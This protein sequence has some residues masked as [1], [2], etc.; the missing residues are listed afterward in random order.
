MSSGESEPD[1]EVESEAGDEIA[2]DYNDIEYI[3]GLQTFYDT[4][5]F[6]SVKKFTSQFGIQDNEMNGN[7]PIDYFELFFDQ[8]L[9]ELI[10]SETNRYQSQNPDLDHEKMAKWKDLTKEELL[11]FFAL[12]ILMG[13]VVKR[14]LKDY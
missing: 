10:C 7:E 13:H 3:P 9:L 11:A 8:P 2:D 6:P 1:S 4:D 12:S 5:F 14:N